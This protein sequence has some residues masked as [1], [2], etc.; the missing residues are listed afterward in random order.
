MF[1]QIFGTGLISTTY[2]GFMYSVIFTAISFF[3]IGIVRGKVVGKGLVR[4][5]L[6]TMGVGGIAALVA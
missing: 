2:I 6:S 4:T 3:L 1:I 5:G